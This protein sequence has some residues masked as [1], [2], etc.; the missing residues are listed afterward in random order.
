MLW[1]NLSLPLANKIRFFPANIR[2]RRETLKP[3]PPCPSIK[4]YSPASEQTR[5]CSAVPTP[6][7]NDGPPLFAR[8]SK[9]RLRDLRRSPFRL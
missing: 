6:S 8:S 3:V 1:S 2:I 9:K 7:R 5:V 4:G